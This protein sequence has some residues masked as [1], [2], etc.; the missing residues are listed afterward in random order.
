MIYTFNE[1][2]EDKYDEINSNSNNMNPEFESARERWFETLDVEELIN[3]GD[4][5]GR[6]VAYET[7]S[8]INDKITKIT[9]QLHDNK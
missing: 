9:L 6:Y 4:D 8:D 7:A 2:L 1:F 5:Y 3:Y